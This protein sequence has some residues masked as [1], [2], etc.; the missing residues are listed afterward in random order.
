MRIVQLS[1][2]HVSASEPRN[3]AFLE[4]A[5]ARVPSVGADLVLLTGDLVDRGTAEEYGQLVDL[6]SAC[7]VPVFVLP[8]NHD[9]RRQLVRTFAQPYLPPEGFV[10]YTLED[11][12]VR[13]VALDTVIPR[14]SGGELCPERLGWLDARLAEAPDKPT[15][16]AMHHP[17]FLSGVAKMDEMGLADP[18]GLEAVIRRHP[19]VERIVCGHLHRTIV[20][21]FAG[22]VACTAPSTAHQIGLD[23]APSRKLTAT[24]DPP[25]MLIHV[26]LGDSLVTHVE[27]IPVA[28]SLTLFDGQDWVV[29]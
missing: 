12:P 5:I 10:Q 14:Q 25:G 22:T 15:L 18:S 19:Q 23:L 17:P 9:D 8:G 11:G 7:A 28:E 6:L 24:W 27:P 29:D 26:W 2:P 20:R 21:R 1:D 4:R 16:V 3:A 13:I